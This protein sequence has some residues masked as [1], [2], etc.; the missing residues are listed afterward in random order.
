M[1]T[2]DESRASD[3]LWCDDLALVSD[4][5]EAGGVY[6]TIRRRVRVGTWQEPLRGVVCRT[7]G[8][9]TERQWLRAALLYAGP[10]AAIS[11]ASAVQLWGVPMDV[12]AVIVTCP[13]G[14]HPPSTPRVRV[15]QSKRPYR[16]L[17]LDG[18]A[19][20]SSARSVLDASLDLRHLAEVDALF[21]R[22][23]QRGLVTVDSLGDELAD[24]PSSGSRLPRLALSELAAGSRA[25]SEAQLVRLLRRSG[26]PMP[27][28]N[29]PVATALGTRFVD[30]LW[31]RLGKGVEVDG[32]AYHLGPAEWRADL[33][34]QNAIQTAGFVLL[35]IAARRLWTEPDAVVREIRWFLGS[36][37]PLVAA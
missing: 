29:A 6:R 24:A 33:T 18:L 13:H 8:Q 31:R 15:R 36:G 37:A 10:S 2:A 4:L 17:P 23:C 7:T 11:H 14:R 9:L 26:L 35:R 1:R 3:T 22:A 5:V 27:E 32:K 19:V 20:T 25:A 34:R 12:D 21:G 28:L 30:A 16:R